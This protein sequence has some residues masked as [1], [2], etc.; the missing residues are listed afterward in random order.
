[1]PDRLFWGFQ[2]YIAPEVVCLLFMTYFL[3]GAWE[4]ILRFSIIYIVTGV[5]F[6]LFIT[7]FI[8]GAWEAVLRF[9]ILYNA[10]SSLP[11]F[12]DIF[13][14]RCLICCLVVCVAVFRLMDTSNNV[15]T[16]EIKRYVM[17]YRSEENFADDNL[18]NWGDQLSVTC[19]S[20][21]SVVH[22]K[23]LALVKPW[24]QIFITST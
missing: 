5:V 13:P 21:D 15:P 7:Y 2:Y 3:L 4:A 18:S 20:V 9:Y 8:L 14:S 11:T 19:G 17:C 22:M 24:Y 12:L 23:G 1:M 6:L 10:W 16:I